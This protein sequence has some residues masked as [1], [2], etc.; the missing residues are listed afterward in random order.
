MGARGWGERRRPRRWRWLCRGQG[1]AEQG[2][3]ARGRVVA[4]VRL[5]FKIPSERGINARAA[6]IEGCSSSS[7]F[8]QASSGGGC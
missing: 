1:G 3:P 8:R 2:R 5:A 6:A 4:G 7:S